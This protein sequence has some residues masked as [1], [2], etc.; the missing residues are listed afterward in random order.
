MCLQCLLNMGHHK[1]NKANN[2]VQSAHIID[3]MLTSWNMNSCSPCTTN[4]QLLAL[5]NK[6]RSIA[7][8]NASSLITKHPTDLFEVEL[9]YLFTN[10]DIIMI[11]HIPLV[12]DNAPLHLM[13]YWSFPIPTTTDM[14]TGLASIGPRHPCH[15]KWKRPTLN[16]SENCRPHGVQ[17]SELCLRVWSPLSLG[18]DLQTVMSCSSLPTT[19][20]CWLLSPYAPWM[21]RIA[22]I[23]TATVWEPVPGLESPVRIQ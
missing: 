17:T 18:N 5:H 19:P 1:V 12:P 10:K 3:S 13:R 8:A 16:G 11:H 9:S 22:R 2:A 4:E 23:C 20:R 21:Y 6:C 15:L 7:K 14:T